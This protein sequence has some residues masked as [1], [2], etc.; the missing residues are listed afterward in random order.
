[1]RL[2]RDKIKP[3]EQPLIS[4]SG[5]V[6]YSDGVITLPVI[7]KPCSLLT[8][9]LVVKAT[10]PYNA[11]LGRQWIH[12]MRAV[13]STYP[14]VLRYPTIYGTE[15]NRGDQA[16]AQTCAVLALKE[17]KGKDSDFENQAIQDAK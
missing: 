13:P 12:K 5:I 10:Y 9:F 4:F 1:M 11:M 7:A 6:T 14:Q 3:F 8:D 2:E 16:T 15:E 17:T